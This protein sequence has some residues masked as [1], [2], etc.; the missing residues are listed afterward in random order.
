MQV[1]LLIITMWNKFIFVISF[2]FSFPIIFCSL[3][4]PL[5]KHQ[6][7]ICLSLVAYHCKLRLAGGVPA[8]DS[9]T[10]LVL[11]KFAFSSDAQTHSFELALAIPTVFTCLTNSCILLFKDT[12]C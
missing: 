3:L 10:K 5:S 7:S 12:K 4:M 1:C 8:Y 2:P 9:L 11:V 6:Y